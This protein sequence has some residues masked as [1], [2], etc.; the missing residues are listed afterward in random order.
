M[1]RDLGTHKGTGSDL[2]D[3]SNPPRPP[4][5]LFG[6]LLTHQVMVVN[7]VERLSRTFLLKSKYG[8]LQDFVRDSQP[9]R[10]ERVMTPRR[11]R[12]ALLALILVELFWAIWLATIVTGATSCRGPI[13]RVATLHHHAAALLACGV[14]CVAG[15][16]GLIPTTRG[17]S[18]CNGREVVGLAMAS[19]A[20]SSSLLGIAALII[21][22]FIV[23]IVL[24]T[25]L[26]AF[27]ATSRREIDDARLRTPF[28]IAV[29][30]GPEQPGTRGVERPS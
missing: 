5:H 11:L 8:L 29:P 30:R 12:W 17:F 24:A 14:F 13:C 23:L 16:A 15:L 22:A 7:F 3:D 20:G 19:A 26:L 10:R 27:T 6:R 2:F 21:A 4:S 9:W 25:F 18:K 1:W 28:P